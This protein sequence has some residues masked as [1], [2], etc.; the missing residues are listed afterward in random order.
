MLHEPPALLSAQGIADYCFRNSVFSREFVRAQDCR[1]RSFL[2]KCFCPIQDRLSPTTIPRKRFATP[3]AEFQS[4]LAP[5]LRIPC[6]VEP[7][8][9]QR[10]TISD[11]HFRLAG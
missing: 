8:S 7:V 10:D 6:R 5:I 2:S 3:P 9:T 11:S 1:S 4:R